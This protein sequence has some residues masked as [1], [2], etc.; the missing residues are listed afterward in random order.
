MYTNMGFKVK[1]LKEKVP[2]C[3]ER[4]SKPNKKSRWFIIVHIESDR[5]GEIFKFTFPCNVCQ[6][7]YGTDAE[8]KHVGCHFI[9]SHQFSNTTRNVCML[10]RSKDNLKVEDL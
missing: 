8:Y 1:T 2:L 7:L 10:A 9:K 4:H 5:A 3:T 6:L